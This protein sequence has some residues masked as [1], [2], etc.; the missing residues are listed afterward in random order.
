MRTAP[1]AGLIG[2]CVARDMK[3]A[4]FPN[5]KSKFLWRIGTLSLMSPAPS[6]L[7]I[8]LPDA[9]PEVLMTLDRDINKT[10]E[11]D[12]VLAQPY[13][14]IDFFRDLYAALV[15]RDGRI[16]TNGIDVQKIGVRAL[17]LDVTDQF[18]A[19]DPRFP[20]L[21]LE[22]FRRF[23]A[24]ANA[25]TAQFIIVPVYQLTTF[26]T[27]QGFRLAEGWRAKQI[28]S[29]NMILGFMQRIALALLENALL[30]PLAPDTQQLDPD[31]EFGP[32][33]YHFTPAVF[34]RAVEIM[35]H[36]P[37]YVQTLSASPERREQIVAA[38][39]QAWA[40]TARD[41]PYFR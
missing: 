31:H 20:A 32:G 17:G 10:F 40:R 21:W 26:W 13:V 15:L 12:A 24:L 39:M 3:T 22:N 19:H 2:A 16:I 1:A 5:T 11:L 6:R 14:V 30:A 38:E 41:S 34:T 33:P 27:P 35:E 18:E 9:A 7:E 36:L 28:V 8:T 23:C 37:E 4:I 29:R 25:S